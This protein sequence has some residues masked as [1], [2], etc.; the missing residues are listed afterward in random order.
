MPVQMLES[1]DKSTWDW[2]A[3]IYLPRGQE[4]HLYFLR[5]SVSDSSWARGVDGTGVEM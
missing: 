1:R 5:G 3:K 4:G 2:D